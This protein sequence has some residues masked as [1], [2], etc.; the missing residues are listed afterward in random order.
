MFSGTPAGY[1]GK[2]RATIWCGDFAFIRPSNKWTTYSNNCTTSPKC[3]AIF[4]LGGCF[5]QAPS[6]PAHFYEPDLRIDTPEDEEPRELETITLQDAKAGR[7]TRQIVL[8]I[9]CCTIIVLILVACMTWSNHLSNILLP[10]LYSNSTDT[11]LCR[12]NI[13]RVSL[14]SRQSV[15]AGEELVPDGCILNG[16]RYVFVFCFI[17]I[18]N[19][20]IRIGRVNVV[21]RI[22][23]WPWASDPHQ[24]RRSEVDKEG[25]VSIV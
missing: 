21:W 13:W 23:G 17:N 12:R 20:V 8:C 18:S 4:W 9:L 2:V 24:V 3:T 6:K 10:F 1:A 16:W 15:D 5:L 14:R 22:L 19:S 11:S 25:S 7:G